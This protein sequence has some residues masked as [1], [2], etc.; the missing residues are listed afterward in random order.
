L[1][2]GFVT[3]P[4]DRTEAAAALGV[5]EHGPVANE[6][7]TQRVVEALRLRPACSCGGGRRDGLRRQSR[8]SSWRR[9]L[10]PFGA[11]PSRP[12]A[13]N[14]IIAETMSKPSPDERSDIRGW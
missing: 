8:S 7:F 11:G 1:R 14:G 6:P 5:D 12:F 4:A 13:G 10:N 3:P 9:L 2:T